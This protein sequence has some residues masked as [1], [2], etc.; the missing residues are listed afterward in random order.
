[1]ILGISQGQKLPFRESAYDRAIEMTESLP[2]R[3]EFI[4]DTANAPSDWPG[5]RSDSVTGALSES[6][7]DHGIFERGLVYST[8]IES[9]GVVANFF[10]AQIRDKVLAVIK[11]SK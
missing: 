6:R 1:M 10:L 5:V 8:G 2:L 11:T 3:D 4:M 7:H 9:L